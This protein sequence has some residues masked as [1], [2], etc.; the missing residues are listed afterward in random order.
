MRIQFRL[1]RIVLNSPLWATYR[2][3]WAS[4]HAG[5]VFV[6][7]RLCTKQIALANRSSWRSGKNSPSWSVVSMPL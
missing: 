1:P 3:G 2:Y 4:G 6:E 5:N 7:N